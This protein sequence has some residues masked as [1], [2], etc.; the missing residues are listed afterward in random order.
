MKYIDHYHDLD[1]TTLADFV[2]GRLSEEEA[3]HVEAHLQ[4]GCTSCQASIGWLVEILS[5]MLGDTWEAPPAP[6][7]ET[8]LQAFPTNNGAASWEGGEPLSQLP[9]PLSSL[10]FA[11]LLPAVND[12]ERVIFLKSSKQTI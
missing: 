4:R 6:V 10:T 9:Y 12:R 7:R 3:F 5:M 1:L 8:V 11:S 2:E